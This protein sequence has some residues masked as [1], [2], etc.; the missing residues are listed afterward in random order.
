MFVD[1]ASSKIIELTIPIE[2]QQ[3]LQHGNTG[4]LPI[5]AGL[6]CDEIVT[7]LEE[8]WSPFTFGY[9]KRLSEAVLHRPFRCLSIDWEGRQWLSFGEGR[10][11]LHVAPPEELPSKLRSEFP[12]ASIPGLT[13][14]VENF[15][16]LVDGYLPPCP[17]FA[18]A[19]EC[20]VVTAN[21]QYY[22]WGRIGKWEGSLTLH[23]TRGG[24]W[25]V[26]SP[27]NRCA[28]WEHD[29]GWES[30]EL[31]PFEELNW[32]L[33]DLIEQYAIYVDLKK[34]GQQ[35]SPFYY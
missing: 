26:I 20:R 14:F 3:Q 6:S 30:D 18:T 27:T 12:F 15:G 4:W 7:M 28:K 23:N 5:V 22:D 1:P 2:P 25:F 29:I 16:G 9:L 17:W 24:N 33:S 8:R 32:S 11:A 13:E 19:S 34:T 21:C 10:E 35:E 31:D